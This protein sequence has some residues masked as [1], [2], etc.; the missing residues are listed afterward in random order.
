MIYPFVDRLE[1]CT[2]TFHSEPLIKQK[3][4]NKKKRMKEKKRVHALHEPFTVQTLVSSAVLRFF[5]CDAYLV[6]FHQFPLLFVA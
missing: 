4:K 5:N 1:I 3:Q 6:Q 2:L